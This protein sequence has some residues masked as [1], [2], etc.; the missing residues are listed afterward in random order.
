MVDRRL[1]IPFHV[2]SP[3]KTQMLVIWATGMIQGLEGITEE[4]QGR[5]LNLHI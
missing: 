4:E 3:Q 1:L 2:P 5:E